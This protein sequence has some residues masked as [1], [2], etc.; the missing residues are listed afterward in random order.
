MCRSKEEHPPN[1]LRCEL[2]GLQR[3]MANIRQALSRHARGA[4]RAR[5]DG[6]Y[7]RLTKCVQLQDANLGRYQRLTRGRQPRIPEVIADRYA[8]PM[9]AHWSDDDLAQEYAK[10]NPRDRREALAQDQILAVLESRQQ[11]RDAAADAAHRAQAS[12]AIDEWGNTE[13]QDSSPLTI[14]TQRGARKLTAKQKLRED[15]DRFVDDQHRQAEND[16]NGKLFNQETQARLDAHLTDSK[17][18]EGLPRD[19]VRDGGRY[20]LQGSLDRVYKYGSPEVIEWCERNGHGSF[21]DFQA[22]YGWQSARDTV[23]KRQSAH[24]VIR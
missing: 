4:A 9:V 18:T 19:L 15:Y 16:C 13:D 20:L 2:H 8:E 12:R 17:A 10:L 5:I 24:A 11:E 6:D 3:K 23:N 14:P 21:T 7:P 1:G 22:H